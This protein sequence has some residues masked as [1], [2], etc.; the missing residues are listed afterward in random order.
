MP[1]EWNKGVIRL[2]PK[3]DTNDPRDPLCYRGI[4]L[5]SIPC[6]VYADILN[7]RFSQWINENNIVVD[8]QNGF[9]RNR[10]CSEH[11]YALYTVINKRKQQKQSTFV[12]FV[13]AKKAFDTV[14]RDC[15]WYKLMSLGIKA[16]I[17]K[18]VQSLYTEVQCVVKV[19][20]YVTPFFD[21][22]HGVKQGCKLSPTLFSLYINDL[23][24]DI[25]QMRLGIDIDDQQL[26]LL[27]Y[28]DDI[29]LIVPDAQSL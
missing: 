25:K 5:I 12:C 16:K 11:I 21:V 15:L 6:K 7:V 2:I 8:E 4:C 19:N 27:L 29:A 18:A 1:S 28:A 13:D 3:S 14:H 22:S 20:Y 26:S 9:R 17:L 10:S 23:A 24:N